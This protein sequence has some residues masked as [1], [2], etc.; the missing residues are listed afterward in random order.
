M[1]LEGR[2]SELTSVPENKDKSLL[3]EL[4]C[5]VERQNQVILKLQEP[6]NR[7]Q[8][9]ETEYSRLQCE[10][11]KLFQRL[12]VADAMARPVSTKNY[13]S[14]KTRTH[15]NHNHSFGTGER[16]PIASS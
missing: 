15:N 14:C 4:R 5:R 12:E 13:A 8:H 7:L 3:E 6:L 10:N 9:L 11:R 2:I 16:D 1:E